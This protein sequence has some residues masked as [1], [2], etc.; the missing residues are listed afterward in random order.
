MLSQRFDRMT[1]FSLFRRA[2]Q[3]VPVRRKGDALCYR[4]TVLLLG[5]SLLGGLS[6]C[7]VPVLVGGGAATSAYLY[8]DRRTFGVIMD[9]NTI[10]WTASSE[11]NQDWEL[12]NP[13]QVHINVT[14]YNTV[15]LL[16]GEVATTAQR[17]RAAEIVRQLPEVKLVYNELAIAPISTTEDRARD[18][19]LTTQVKAALLQVTVPGF[20]ATRVKVVTERG[21]VYLLGLLRPDEA[22]AAV[23]EARYVD[24]VQQVVKLFEVIPAAV[25]AE[26]DS[27]EALPLTSPP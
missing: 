6:G 1:Q 2:V 20:N 11:F 25:P 26:P 16:T 15:V 14:S 19:A 18:A 12:A 3:S 10:E 5:L 22:Q 23:E 21:V 17:Q 13:V 7:L 9:D 24:A 4:L 8:Q 27:T